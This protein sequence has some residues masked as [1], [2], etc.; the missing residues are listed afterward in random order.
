MMGCGSKAGGTTAE[1]T[2]PVIPPTAQAK[3]V[4]VIGAGMAG[5]KA[6]NKLAKAGFEVL[7]LEGRDRIG[8]RTWSN[9]AMGTP[10]DMGA[11][12]IHGIQ[13]NPIYAL[14][15]ELAVPLEQWDY[16]D[17]VIYDHQGNIDYTIA[18]YMQNQQSNLYNWITT[19]LANDANATVQDA[20]DVGV[21]SGDLAEPVAGKVLFAG[22]ATHAAYPSTVHGAYLSGE[23]EADRIIAAGF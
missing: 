17:Q 9:N 1:P 21:Q 8:G 15:T 19:A 3:K 6:A 14:A 23:R 20:F 13:N 2:A 10:L 7:V 4:V 5:I 22:E 12:W 16:D 11:S 18:G